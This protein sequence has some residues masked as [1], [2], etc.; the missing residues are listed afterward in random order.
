[1]KHDQLIT[2][3]PAPE[4][5]PLPASHAVTS[6]LLSVPSKAE[7]L[8]AAVLMLA[9]ISTLYRW[10]R[11]PRII[12]CRPSFTQ[13]DEIHPDRVC[14]SSVFIFIVW[15]QSTMHPFYC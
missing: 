14:S 15:W 5:T 1:M 4:T 2:A 8:K 11:T 10:N 6:T 13:N 7:S 12:L 3:R 9:D